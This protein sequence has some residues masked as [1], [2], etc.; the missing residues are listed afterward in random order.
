MDLAASM[1]DSPN[2]TYEETETLGA[3]LLVRKVHVN[4]TKRWK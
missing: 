3:F 1:L 2:H 4:H